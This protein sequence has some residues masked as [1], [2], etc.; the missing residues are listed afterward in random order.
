[1]YLGIIAKKQKLGENIFLNL[2]RKHAIPGDS[3]DDV[4]MSGRCVRSQFERIP[5]KT[6]KSGEILCLKTF[7]FFTDGVAF[8]LKVD[9]DAKTF[10]YWFPTDEMRAASME[11]VRTEESLKRREITSKLHFK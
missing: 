10:R 8:E 6:R 2:L 4:I 9:T 3:P 11:F 5:G 7:Y 1:M